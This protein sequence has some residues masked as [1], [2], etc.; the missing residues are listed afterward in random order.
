MTHYWRGGEGIAL[1]VAWHLDHGFWNILL[2][3]ILGWIY[4]AYKL[5]Q[6]AVGMTAIWTP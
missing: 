4:V 1:G 3:T 5:T 6:F 2:D